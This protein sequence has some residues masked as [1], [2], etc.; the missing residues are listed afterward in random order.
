MPLLARVV[1]LLLAVIAAA[2][3]DDTDVVETWSQPTGAHD[4]SCDDIQ[5]FADALVDTGI[6]YDYTPSESPAALATSADS[7]FGGRVTGNVASQQTTVTED[8]VPWSF[9]G[10]EI[11]VTRVVSGSAGPAEGDL[12]DVFV[13][14]A[15]TLHRDTDYYTKAVAPGAEVAVFA[16]EHEQLGELN[17]SV[18]G[19]VTACPGGPLLGWVGDQDEWARVGTVEEVLDAAD[20]TARPTTTA[21]TGATETTG[22]SAASPRGELPDLHGGVNGPV[23]YGPR[24]ESDEAEAALIEGTL[25]RDGDCLYVISEDPDVPRYP[26]M[27]PY[28][29]GWQQEPEG[30]V[31]LDGMFL[32]VGASFSSGGGYHAANTFATRDLPESIIERADGCAEGPYREVAVV[33]TT[34]EVQ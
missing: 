9:I 28:G 32:P 25:E 29:A 34:V 16:Y 20:N 12:V 1:V 22:A 13:E 18:E 8:P 33:Q 4:P 21:T 15:E 14:Y 2:C 7:V 10:Y 17:A 26:I 24:P 23:M 19:F 3:G 27:W 6:T 30:V 31:L 5:R 11:E